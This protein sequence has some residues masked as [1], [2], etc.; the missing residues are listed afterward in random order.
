MKKKLLSTLFITILLFNSLSSSVYANQGGISIGDANIRETTADKTIG[1]ED[2]G[3]YFTVPFTESIGMVK[4]KYYATIQNPY[5]VSNPYVESHGINSFISLGYIDIGLSN[6]PDESLELEDIQ[7]SVSSLVLSSLP[8]SSLTT[9]SGGTSTPS[10]G[11]SAGRL[12]A[13]K[14]E[15]WKFISLNDSAPSVPSAPPA[16]PVPPTEMQ[17]NFKNTMKRLLF[18]TDDLVSYLICGDSEEEIPELWEKYLHTDVDADGNERIIDSSMV[19]YMTFLDLGYGGNNPLRSNR[20]NFTYDIIPSKRNLILDDISGLYENFESDKVLNNE[21]INEN[22]MSLLIEGGMLFPEVDSDG[23]EY[24]FY[25]NILSPSIKISPYAPLGYTY[26]QQYNAS[27]EPSSDLSGKADNIIVPCDVIEIGPR[28]ARTNDFISKLSEYTPVTTEES[29]LKENRY[30]YIINSFLS[31]TA[32]SDK[33]YE[34]RTPIYVYSIGV[35]LGIGGDI[36]H[37]EKTF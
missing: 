1:I 33:V 19:S 32:E 12:R 37:D 3:Y 18:L 13:D 2:E 8:L 5:T 9:N 16:S 35:S 23:R 24:P 7:M 15:D 22:L 10:P 36:T 6:T 30:W 20:S 28:I 14:I 25:R 29:L 21:N 11:E 31:S 34:T 27:H 26:E 4:P 17:N